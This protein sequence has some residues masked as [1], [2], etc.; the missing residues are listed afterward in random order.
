MARK[1]RRPWLRAG[2]GLAGRRRSG[3]K[4]FCT[5]VGTV[6]DGAF[7]Q[8]AMRVH[9]RRR[10]RPARS[11]R[12]GTV[13][14]GR[15]T[16][17]AHR[18]SRRRPSLSQDRCRI[19]RPNRHPERRGL[20]MSGGGCGRKSRN[21]SRPRPFC[22]SSW[23]PCDARSAARFHCVMLT[24]PQR[25]G[26]ASTTGQ[27]CRRGEQLEDGCEERG[28]AADQPVGSAPAG[29]PAG[30]SSGRARVSMPIAARANPAIR[31]ARPKDGI[32]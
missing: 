3:A 1:T 14:Q 24:K 7:D 6:G 23:T 25:D 11:S 31:K 2:H 16:N 28:S 19:R 17:A 29:V 5:M 22:R 15:C 27:V 30:A 8:R 9:P 13:F 18:R 12:S 10:Y 32:A 21:R 20:S 4:G 26:C